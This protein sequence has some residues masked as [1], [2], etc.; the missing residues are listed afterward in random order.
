MAL[1]R[2]PWPDLERWLR[3]TTGQ[4]FCD[5][6]AWGTVG[7]ETLNAILREHGLLPHLINRNKLINLA[8]KLMTD[9]E[10]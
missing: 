10:A 2:D 9:G 5:E 1:T 7:F 6:L 8:N 4:E 3:T